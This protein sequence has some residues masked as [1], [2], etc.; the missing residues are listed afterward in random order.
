MYLIL[1]LLLRVT[2]ELGRR[3]G[4]WQKTMCLRNERD[5]RSWSTVMVWDSLNEMLSNTSVE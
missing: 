1:E 4:V 3:P 2:A 5:Q